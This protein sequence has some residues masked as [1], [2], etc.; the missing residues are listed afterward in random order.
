MPNI[1]H[2]FHELPGPG[3]GVLAVVLPVVLP[4]YATVVGVRVGVPVVGILYV[5]LATLVV[6]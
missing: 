6:C 1:K 5:K 3:S 2:Q 4:L